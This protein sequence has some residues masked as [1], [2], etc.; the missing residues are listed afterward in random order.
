MF[1]EPP[2]KVL[3]CYS[4]WTK[5]FNE[6]EKNLDIEFVQGMP[7]P[8]KIKDIFDGHHHIICVDD[9]QHEVANS[10]EAEKLFTQLSHHNN[11]SVIYLNQNL[12]F[13]GKCART[14]NLNTAY[15]VLLK[16]PRN[17]QQVALLGHQLG[18]GKTLQEAYKDATGKSFGYL[19]V[20]LSPK[21]D[22]NYRLR[23]NVFPEE[24]PLLVYQ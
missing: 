13:Q 16:N 9:L 6:M 19:V 10:K 22:E 18:I 24:A 8:D 20:D 1:E 3:Y 23:T 17:T 7:H 4:I 12:Y 2:K 11:L 15:I 14:L 21:S 5:L